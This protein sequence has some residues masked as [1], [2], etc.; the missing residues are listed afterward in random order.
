MPSCSQMRLQLLHFHA[1]FKTWP[2]FQEL[3]P[4]VSFRRRRWSQRNFS[5][6]RNIHGNQ[7]KDMLNK[8]RRLR[9]NIFLASRCWR[10]LP[11]LLRKLI[12]VLLKFS[13]IVFGN[14][15]NVSC[16]S[17]SAAFEFPYQ[18]QLIT[19]TIKMFDM[20]HCGTIK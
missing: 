14:A 10:C 12:I 16:N 15:R 13:V 6:N 17:L 1:V 9:R 11:R 4:I 18:L 19:F 8:I 2:T 5:E 7:S 3:T 20:E